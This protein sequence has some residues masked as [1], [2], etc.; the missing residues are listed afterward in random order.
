MA[1]ALALISSFVSGYLIIVS[2]WPVRPW[3]SYDRLL[4]ASLSAGFGVGI[5]S[6]IFFLALVLRLTHLLAADLLA[7]AALLAAFLLLSARRTPSVNLPRAQES[8]DLPRW[9]RLVLRASFWFAVAAG[10]YSAILRS[11]VH[12][13]GDGWD[14]FA[15]WNL[16][17]RFLFRGGQRWR[18]GFSPLIP[19]SHPDYPLLVPS[20]IAH[21][22][23][24]LGHE[25]T[26]IPAV[27]GVVFSFATLGLLVSGLAILRGRTL[28]MLGGLALASTPYFIEL[29]SAQYADVPLSF[30]FL[31]VMVLLG[32]DRDYRGDRAPFGSHGLLA[33]AGIAAGFAVWTKNEGMLFLLATVVAQLL[34]EARQR[35]RFLLIFLPAIAPFLLLIGWFK[36][37]VAFPNELFSGHS[38]MLH[39]MLDPS[40]Y[41]VIFRWLVKDFFRFGQWWPAPTTLLLIGF[42][43][44]VFDKR[45]SQT[46][47]NIRAL[48]LTLALTFAGYFAIYVITPYD[49]YWHLRF[50]LNRLFLQLWPCA[51]F[52]FFLAVPAKTREKSQNGTKFADN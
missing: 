8:P 6:V 14:A 23:S 41:W 18:D 47:Y 7:S 1:I 38:G 37:S 3:S 13:Q 17:A 9:L 48:V 21:F 31:A 22:W 10:L 43:L 28:A 29:G 19:W 15:I 50:S 33:L 11:I 42:Y 27:I 4:R 40:R 46:G 34:V 51:L 24:A 49:L 12:P 36:H 30:F 52:L 5:F 20:A 32:L 39:K 35:T 26:A 2:G 16:H 44:V 45:K 25:S